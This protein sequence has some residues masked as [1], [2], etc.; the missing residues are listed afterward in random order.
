MV[1]HIQTTD[2][3][4]NDVLALIRTLAD[5]KIKAGFVRTE[6]TASSEKIYSDPYVRKRKRVKTDVGYKD[7]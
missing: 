6:K 1:L 5:E 7:A 4:V 2:E 3:A